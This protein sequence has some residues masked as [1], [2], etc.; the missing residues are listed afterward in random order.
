MPI[1]VL[2]ALV[3]L[4]SKQ[5]TRK[6]M[7]TFLGGIGRNQA[8]LIA[9]AQAAGLPGAQQL[10]RLSPQQQL[11]ISNAPETLGTSLL[12]LDPRVAG[13]VNHVAAMLGL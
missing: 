7:P 8:Q 11:A 12:L 2:L 4:A 13:N 5:Q 10:S 6:P 9:A 3:A 1:L